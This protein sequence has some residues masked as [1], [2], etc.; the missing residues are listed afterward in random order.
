MGG[1]GANAEAIA[2]STEDA[3]SGLADMGKSAR[4]AAKDAKSG[5][6]SFDMLNNTTESIADSTES[7]AD[8]LAMMGGANTGTM[9]IT[10]TVDADTT[11]LDSGLAKSIENIKT[12]L[13]LFNTWIT[14]SFAPIFSNIW[15]N[16]QPGILTFKNTVSGM[17][18]DI[19]TL[20]QPLL[21]YFTGS[22]TPMLQTHFTTLGTIVTGL[23]DTFNTVFSDI[24]NIAVFP[25]IE[26]FITVILPMISE[27]STQTSELIGVI[28]TEV[29]R[30]F[31]MIW[32]EAIAPALKIATDIWTDFV[33]ILAE[34]WNKWGVPI[35][36]GIKEAWQSTSDL[37][38]SLWNSF[39]KPI[40]DKWMEV[41]EELWNDHLK[42]L[43]DNFMDFVGELAKGATD[44]YNEFIAPILKWFVEE[45]GP[46]ISDVITGLIDNF[47]EFF[48]NI[49]DA[50]SGI[51]TAL[52][53]IV[54][55]ITGIFTGD[56][57][58]AWE[59]VKNIFKGIF[60]ALVGIVK[61]PIN[62]IIDI[63]N[64]MISGIV[65]GINAVIN[66]VNKISFEMPATPFSKAYTVGFDLKAVTAPKIPRLATGAV[67]PPNSEFLALLGDQNKGTNIEA[68][69]D[70]IVKAF[71]IAN[72]ENGGGNGTEL[73][74]HVYEDGK[75]R[76]ETVVKYEKQNYGMTGKSI[77][78]H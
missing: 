65:T 38:V 42:P 25:M 9:G 44:I 30:I 72:S 74:L 27:F 40:W 58:K 66:A 34:F 48:G 54:Q 11:A 20:G 73:H 57:E 15:T 5:T 70:T 35:F 14:T 28:F 13:S 60:D 77:F 36:D 26:K 45:F 56:W 31:D 62:L 7:A 76:F 12:G 61:T 18:T 2:V 55:F 46:P 52:K 19:K 53:G 4:K 6:A 17:F 51:I 47:G 8:S 37:F 3:S 59:G 21:D 50:V 75:Q 68:P 71:K 41:I 67:I 29:K 64:G 63:I 22:F 43:V 78:V 23:F 24:W 32:K 10:A 16:L 39:L 33:D 69:L 49:V 1:T